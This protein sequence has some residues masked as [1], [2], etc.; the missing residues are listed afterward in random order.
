MKKRIA[1]VAGGDS[2]EKVI[3]L[4]TAAVICK[5][6]NENPLYQAIQVSIEFGKWEVLLDGEKAGIDKNDFS[7]IQN[8]KKINFDAAFIGIHGTPGED[9]KL[10]GYFDLI[11]MPYTS[12]GQLNSAVTFNKWYCNALLRQLGFNC[13][14]S[15]LLRAE[16]YSLDDVLQIT[17]KVGFPCFVKP[18]NGGSS[19]GIS[20]VKDARDLSKAISLAFEHGDE[21]MIEKLMIGREVTC[22]LITK[23]KKI[24]VL[25]VT[26]ILPKGDFFDYKAKYEGNSEEITPA[27]LPDDIYSKIQETAKDVYKK[28]G[29]K[30][31][32]RIDF[33]IQ[34]Q[35]VFIIEINTIPGLST[36]SLVP[37]QARH[38]G[39][40]LK[41][42]FEIVVEECLR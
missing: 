29:L 39:I 12:C 5:N 10:Q 35:D 16:K 21:V 2:S 26:E 17:K 23:N 33:M 41:E 25:P 8:G 11:G 24:M 27:D 13:S 31:L 22:G 9:G 36:E 34:N 38:A 14:E 32:V 19:F 4:K 6:L 7:Y 15:Y 28:M 1:V 20:K 40:E 18:N 3:S 42:L 30:G 37:Q